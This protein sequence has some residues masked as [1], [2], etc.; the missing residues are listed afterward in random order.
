MLRKSWVATDAGRVYT[1]N[2]DAFLP[3]TKAASTPLPTDLAVVPA[4]LP[5]AWQCKGLSKPRPTCANSR[6]RASAMAML[7][8][9]ATGYLTTFKTSLNELTW[10]YSIFRVKTPTCKG[11]PR[12]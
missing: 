2:H 10:N 8:S 7:Q 3:A 12:R 11:P 4:S 9:R 5:V 1:S 6:L